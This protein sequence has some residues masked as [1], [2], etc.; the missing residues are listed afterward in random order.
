MSLI[1]LLA[2]HGQHTRHSYLSSAVRCMRAAV[3]LEP[4]NAVVWN[5]LGV[6]CA[7]EREEQYDALRRAAQLDKQVCSPCKG[8]CFSFGY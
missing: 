5:G 1:S 6:V 2:G 4:H 8:I 3:A 7:H